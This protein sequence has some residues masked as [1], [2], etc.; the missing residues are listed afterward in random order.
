[1]STL[2]ASF[3]FISFDYEWGHV[4]SS[5]VAASVGGAILAVAGLIRS[6]WLG[7]A[8]Y[9]WLGV[10]LTE[11]LAY[12]GPE[13]EVGDTSTGGWS[14]IGASAGL[15]AGSYALRVVQ[16]DR[17]VLDLVCGVA[18]AIAA[19]TGAGIGV[20]WLADDRT[21]TGLGWLAAASI[22][23]ALT[24][25]V[26][27]RDGLRDFSTTLWLLALAGIVGAEI[28][29]IEDSDARS[30]LIATTALAVGFIAG[31]LREERLWLAGSGLVVGTTAVALAFQVKP[32]L[33]EA[34]LDRDYAFVAAACAL[35]AFALAALRWRDAGSDGTAWRDLNTVVWA[36]GIVALL[37][38][39]RLAVGDWPSTIFVV[40]LTAGVIALV[41]AP[42]GE[43]RLWLAGVL[44]ASIA[45]AVT[46]AALTS[47]DNFFR[48]SESPGEAL[49]V[50][51]ACVA[52]LV[53]TAATVPTEWESAR[54]PLAAAAGIVALYA[55]SLG[56]LE[57]AERISG[58]SVETDFERGHTAVSGFWAL[59]GLGLLIAGLLRGSA[60][61]RYGG[62]ALFGLS[63]AKIFLYDLAELD[64]V[65]RAF[66]FIFVGGLLLVGGFFLQRLSDRLGPPR[67]D[68]EQEVE[69]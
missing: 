52:A 27:R 12:D 45:T 7:I 65:A 14:I 68:V 34:E 63:L 50:L 9:V 57:I 55:A 22:L 47:P 61:L 30:V 2:G 43:P 28:A 33:D 20:P 19:L 60:F 21:A 36:T 48:A 53:V 38:A 26:F 56:I 62:L 3:L 69:A 54:L 44:I 5:A 66:S 18:V 67:T 42:S 15:L 4:A 6:D 51:I 11:A 1:M 24:A 35:T 58:A 8:A 25:G 64:S 46:L 49:W 41:A 29:L 23:T 59:L 37:A 10:V 16:A 32:W 31:P 40:A 13:F 17:R 39:E